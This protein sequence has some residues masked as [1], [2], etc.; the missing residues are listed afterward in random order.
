[1]TII[2]TGMPLARPVNSHAPRCHTLDAA[3]D[4]RENTTLGA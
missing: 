4:G 3:L 1:M 2:K